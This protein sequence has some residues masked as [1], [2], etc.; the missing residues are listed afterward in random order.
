M[1]SRPSHQ[2]H[3]PPSAFQYKK[4]PVLTAGLG[5][6]HREGAH[7]P[8]TRPE[9]MRK[10][11]LYQ[12]GQAGHFPRYTENSDVKCSPPSQ[13]FYWASKLPRSSL[14]NCFSFSFHYL[15]ELHNSFIFITSQNCLK[16]WERA[17]WGLDSRCSNL[18]WTHIFHGLQ[19]GR[20][21][22]R[23]SI[24]FFKMEKIIILTL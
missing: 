14:G 8:C 20:I 15:H 5:R 9:R 4:V 22:Q 10:C 7:G 18:G 17:A 21:L 19:Q 6:L 24:F 1:L 3:L 16:A 11:S 13:T 12:G 2:S 23:F